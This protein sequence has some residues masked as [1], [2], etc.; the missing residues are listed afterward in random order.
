MLD[1]YFFIPGDKPNFLNKIDKIE[2][3]F[4]VLDLEDAVSGQNKQSAIAGILALTV[5]SNMFVRLPFF[6]GSFTDLDLLAMI[7]KFNGQ[8]V[9]P[10]FKNTHD[11]EHV[12]SL[13]QN[14]PL[15]MIVLV[16]NPQ[17][18]ITVS[19][20]LKRFT[21]NIHAIGFG[22]HDFC[23]ITGT[24]HTLEYLSHYKQQLILYAKAYGVDFIDGV[25]LNLKDYTVFINECQF[26]FEAG[27]G[28]KFLIHPKQLQVMNNIAFISEEERNQMQGVYDK[29]KDIPVDQIEVYTINGVVYEKPHIQRI[30]NWMNKLKKNEYGS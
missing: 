16:E 22:S 10:K 5:T 2:A 12:A 18:F 4:I 30:K 23:S 29:V 20:V 27:A 19:E 21:K 1:S 6:D 24:K 11:I 15:K 25:D 8:I 28:G 26:A 14:Q 9:V 3:D 13:A 7:T 17:A